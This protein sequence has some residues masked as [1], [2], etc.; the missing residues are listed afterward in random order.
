MPVQFESSVDY[1]WIM[2]LAFYLYT[3]L[4][5]SNQSSTLLLQQPFYYLP[6]LTSQSM[7]I[8]LLEILL[9]T[10]HVLL[11][12]NQYGF[13]SHQMAYHPTKILLLFV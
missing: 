4:I 2:F 5:Q 7:P 13:D 3:L 8:D 12:D 6:L 11:A 9:H 10:Y 1:L